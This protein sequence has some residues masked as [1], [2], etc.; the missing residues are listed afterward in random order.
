MVIDSLQSQ[1]DSALLAKAYHI[2]GRTLFDRASYDSALFFQ[3]KGLEYAR[4][5]G[6]LQGEADALRQIGVLYWYAGKPDSACNPF[7]DSALSLYGRINDRIGEATT[8]NNIGLATGNVLRCLEAFAIRKRIG[9]QVGLADSYYF[10]TSPVRGGYWNDLAYNFRMK[11]LRLSTKIGYAWGRDVAARA[12]DQMVFGSYDSLLFAQAAVETTTAFGEGTILRLQARSVDYARQ[13]NW[14]EN[15]LFCERIVQLCDSLD[16][17][18]GLGMAL[19]RY[20]YALAKLGRHAEAEKTAFRLQQVWPGS[21]SADALLAQVYHIAGRY[22]QALPIYRSLVGSY[23]EMYRQN[24]KKNSMLSS[25]GAGNVL[26]DR[27]VLYEMLISCYS[28]APDAP[29]AFL[30]LEQFRAIS[31]GLG[32]FNEEEGPGQQYFNTVEAIENGDPDMDLLM[33]ELGDEYDR[34]EGERSTLLEASETVTLQQTGAL[35]DI[36]QALN[37]DE[38][39]LEY[40][41]GIEDAYVFIIRKDLGILVQLKA[42]VSDINSSTRTFLELILRGKTTSA[43]SLWKGP[44]AFL[45]ASLVQPIESFIGDSGHLIVSPHGLLHGIPFAALLDEHRA[46]LIDRFTISTVRSASS[47]LD[48]KEPQK[49]IGA[50]AFVPDRS[51]LQF[52][53]E[54]ANGIPSTL[55]SGK[56]TLQDER[57]TTREF[58]T[59]S[60]RADLIHIA[61]HGSVNRFHPL[62]SQLQMWDRPLELREIIRN[63][64]MARLVVISACESGYGVGM[65]GDLA[66][67]H[68][69]VSFPYAFLSAGASAVLSPLWIVEDRSTA[70]LMGL[71]YSNLASLESHNKQP[72]RATYPLALARAQRQFLKDG[73]NQHPF[74]WAG[75]QLMH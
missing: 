73:E 53:E 42:P 28:K 71:F 4:A 75:F 6:S 49:G 10:V 7:Y 8:L 52:A 59:L 57:A 12:V 11:S 26:Y 3:Q 51:S 66:Y 74:Y 19:Q 46:H 54:E 55:F 44:A 13:G 18:P 32:T 38:V 23:D 30:A 29:A 20:A 65:L 47:I 24:L 37:A 68:V 67:G 1:P 64:F 48:L 69:I 39:V 33:K 36:Q 62:F 5:A 25:L 9:D 41:L 40:F 31:S 17:T 60:P 27:L 21:P 56:M 61:A 15:A 43:D 45:Y 72:S 34:S 16:Y 35:A 2:I 70:T 50:I 58:L 63:K 22:G 14:K